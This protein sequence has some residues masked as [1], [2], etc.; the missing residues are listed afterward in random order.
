MYVNVAVLAETRAHEGRVALVPSL[1]ARLAKLG[2]RL[3]MQAGAGS[4]A[5]LDDAVFADVAI[6][7]DRAAML[8]D[9][10]VVPAVQAPD[11]GVVDAMKPGSMLICFVYADKEEALVQRVV[12]RKI[13]CFAMERLPRISPAQAMDALSS[14]SALAGYYAV[15]LG[16]THLGR[17]CPR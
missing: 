1:V 5:N 14:Q 7:T 17:S 9:A 4:A 13:T 8:H 2:A 3:H 10:D 15:Q 12:D 16:S 11:V 6:A